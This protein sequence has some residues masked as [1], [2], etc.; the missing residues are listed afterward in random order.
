MGTARHGAKIPNRYSDTSG[1]ANDLQAVHGRQKGEDDMRGMGYETPERVE[2]SLARIAR[3]LE[4]IAAAEEE[5]NRRKGRR[6]DVKAV[7]A[8][9]E[10][11]P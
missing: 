3:A 11:E 10:D 6:I 8:E 4:R 5:R 1:T 2:D 7:L 9:E